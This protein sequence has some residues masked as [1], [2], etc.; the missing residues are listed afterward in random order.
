MSS[1]PFIVAAETKAMYAKRDQ[2]Q[3]TSPFLMGHPP[4][5][6][7]APMMTP[8]QLQFGGFGTN[9]AG[10]CRSNNQADRMTVLL[11]DV[12]DLRADRCIP[13]NADED[14]Y[15]LTIALLNALYDQDVGSRPCSLDEL[16]FNA[17]GPRAVMQHWDLLWVT[18]EGACI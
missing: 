6:P 5:A 18:H 4:M 1:N 15:I 12:I 7:M 2:M 9:G 10:F 14:V 16:R 13:L 3:A 11:S 8:Q 17:G